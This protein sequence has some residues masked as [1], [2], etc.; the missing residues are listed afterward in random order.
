MEKRTFCLTKMPGRRA[1]A[2]DALRTLVVDA[3]IMIVP[4][5]PLPTENLLWGR[6]TPRPCE[7][8]G[9]MGRTG[10]YS[11][12]GRYGEKQKRNSIAQHRS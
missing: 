8:T 10:R 2:G 4:G 1:P 9:T 3:R 11:W 5:N 12:Y 6:D 7:K